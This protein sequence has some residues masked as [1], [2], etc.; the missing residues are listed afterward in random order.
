MATFIKKSQILNLFKIK[1]K[2]KYHMMTDSK[3]L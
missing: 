1:Q 2:K 3:K